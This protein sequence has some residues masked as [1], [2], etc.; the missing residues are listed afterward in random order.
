M[1]RISALLPVL[2]PFLVAA[3]TYDPMVIDGARWLNHVVSPFNEHSL[4]PLEFGEDTVINGETYRVI[5]EYGGYGAM[6]E[7]DR[8]VWFMPFDE[9]LAWELDTVPALLYDFNLQ[10]GDLYTL[11]MQPTVQAEVITKDSVQLMDGTYRDRWWF[12]PNQGLLQQWVESIGDPDYVLSS[13]NP[14]WEVGIWLE[15]YGVNNNALFGSCLFLGEGPAGIAAV[16][17]FRAIPGTVAGQFQLK[18]PVASMQMATVL[19]MNGRVVWDQRGPVETI[20]LTGQGPG[21]YMLSIIA[22]DRRSVLRLMVPRP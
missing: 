2:L 4:V 8:R 17:E 20:D 1:N 13:V 19:D 10:V 18:G 7:E 22:S 9:S 15:C 5:G 3:Q 21:L 16:E 11:P 6:R 12:A 14:Y